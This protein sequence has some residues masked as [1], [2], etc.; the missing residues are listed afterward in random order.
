MSNNLH[1][2]GVNAKSEQVRRR[3]AYYNKTSSLHQKEFLDMVEVVRV[4]QDGLRL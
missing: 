4:H 3:L 2:R 1:M